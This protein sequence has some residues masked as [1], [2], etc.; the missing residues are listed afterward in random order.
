MDNSLHL[1]WA[2]RSI[3]KV[4]SCFKQH[5]INFLR[6]HMTNSVSQVLR[7]F[8]SAQEAALSNL[9]AL[10][11]LVGRSDQ[12]AYATTP[13][14]PSINSN[15]Q[16]GDVAPAGLYTPTVGDRLAAEHAR[17]EQPRLAVFG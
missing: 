13:G 9:I 1:M 2:Q 4:P 5:L 14:Q 15:S 11:S 12:V 6:R 3:Y 17:E 7:R 10:N 8:N 16:I